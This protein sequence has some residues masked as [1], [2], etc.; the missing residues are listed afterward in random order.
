MPDRLGLYLLILLAAITIGFAQHGEHLHHDIQ[1]RHT[2]RQTQTMWNVRNFVRH[3]ANILNPRTAAFNGDGDNLHRY[4]FPIMQWTIAAAQRIFGERIQIAR[5][6]MY[7]FSAVGV[8]GMFLLVR[9]LTGS[10]VVGL[11]TAVLFQYAPVVFYYAINPL[12]D[13]FALSAGVWYLYLINRY[14]KRGRRGVL[15]WAGLALLLA[16]LAKLPYLMLSVVSIGYFI[17]DLLA[18]KGRSVAPYRDAATQLLLVTPA[19]AWY[20]W[21]I[22]SWSG[23]PILTGSIGEGLSVAEKWGLIRFHLKEM[24]PFTLLGPVCWIPFALGL[25]PLFR[26]WRVH[27]WLFALI[28]ITVLY[29]Y[30]ELQPIGTAHDY[31]M[32]PFLAW[33]FPV[34]G[35]GLHQLLRWRRLRY[36]LPLWCL[37]AAL[38]TP[39][40]VDYWWS[41]QE[42]YFNT[43]Y[44]IHAEALREAVPAGE[45]VIIVND[46][47]SFIYPYYVDKM[48]HIF[49]NDGIPGAYVGD[50][51]SKYGVR[52]L[53]S[54]SEAFNERDDNAA[55]LGEELLRA[56][57]VSVY[58]LKLPEE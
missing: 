48:G 36:T 39:R 18:G 19:L 1:G 3:D 35:L 34:V 45:Q 9:Q 23:N 6:L 55:Y 44:L 17:G 54:D 46:V 28:G 24:F 7:L 37:A 31:Y 10:G 58:R 38:Y 51:Y 11:V 22:G 25:M 33:L 20:A 43:D 4:E 5:Y 41:V 42:S 15:L 8:F 29:L 13:V 32:F 27:G 40:A 12:P 26:Q 50:I 30:L 53:Y 47:S 16:T 52:Y 14:R 49:P 56:G 2:W 21:V 57:S